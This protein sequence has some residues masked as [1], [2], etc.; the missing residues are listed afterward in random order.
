MRFLITPTPLVALP[1]YHTLIIAFIIAKHL[2]D[3]DINVPH[4]APTS[5][6]YYSAAIHTDL[7]NGRNITNA[8][9]QHR[10]TT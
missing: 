7:V 3:I 1:A 10:C 2:P 6:N 5:L 4:H 8:P 9:D